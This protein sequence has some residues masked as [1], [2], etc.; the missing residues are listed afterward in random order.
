MFLLLSASGALCL[1]A[2]YLRLTSLR[3]PNYPPGPRS[4]P[5]FGN[6]LDLDSANPWLT[7]CRWGKQFGDILSFKIFTRRIVVINSYSIAVDL[8]DKRSSIYSDRPNLMMLDLMGWG[9]SVAFMRYADSRRRK[10]R[11]S[12]HTGLGPPNAAAMQ[13]TLLQRSDTLVRQLLD[14]SE[15]FQSHLVNYAAA[16]IMH[17]TFG[18]TDW[19]KYKYLVHDVT[20]K[21]INALSESVFFGAQ[22]VFAFPI[23]QMGSL[24]VVNHLPE[25]LPGAGFK[26]IAREQRALTSRLQEEPMEIVKKQMATGIHSSSWVSDL[27]EERDS[28]PPGALTE[29]NIKELAANVFTGGFDTANVI[30]HLINRVVG[31][32]RLPDFGDR[33]ALPYLSAIC[34]EALRWHPPIPLAGHCVSETDE[35]MGYEIPA[36]TPVMANIWAMTRDASMFKDPDRFYPERFIKEDGSLDE[37]SSDFVW[38][39][40][41]RTCPGR[42]FAE[43]TMWI[44]VARILAVYNIHKAIDSHGR[45]IPVKEEYADR[46]LF[47]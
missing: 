42:T 5:V 45:E 16:S 27:F 17:H 41:R 39:F 21:A 47:V 3:G 34:R 28:S 43:L 14:S 29:D 13:Q 32:Q 33:E 23:L 38:G 30:W 12:M 40:S 6:L 1:I 4:L 26:R 18:F 24:G 9:F 20:L 46:G 10:Y 35:Y 22:A 2:L 7:Y 15:G 8:L 36:G 44:A 11:R 19:N 25:W 37:S 31:Q